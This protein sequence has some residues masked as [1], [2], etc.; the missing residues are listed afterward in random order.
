MVTTTLGLVDDSWSHH[1][2]VG[3]KVYITSR[4]Q[5]VLESSAQAHDPKTGGTIIACRPCDVTKKDEI[6]KL[7]DEIS[8]KEHRVNHLGMLSFC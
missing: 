1:L 2:L 8:S 6:Q 4:R 7:V 5:E 3:A